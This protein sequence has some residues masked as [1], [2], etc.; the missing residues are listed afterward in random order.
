MLWCSDRW[1]K[2]V[3]LSPKP[4]VRSAPSSTVTLVPPHSDYWDRRGLFW[5]GPSSCMVGAACLGTLAI[6]R[7]LGGH[8]G[9]PLPALVLGHPGFRV[10]HGA[11]LSVRPRACDDAKN[12]ATGGTS[13]SSIARRKGNT[14]AWPAHR[15]AG[16]IEGRGDLTARTPAALALGRT[17]PSWWRS[18]S[19]RHRACHEP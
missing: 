7:S 9:F 2:L 12:A 18:R 11:L 15:R 14:S 6:A 13:R 16:G 1:W 17:A 19:H 3:F 8:L 5:C 10:A 4:S